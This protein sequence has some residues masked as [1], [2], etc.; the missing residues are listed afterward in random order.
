[1]TARPRRLWTGITTTVQPGTRAS[2]SQP[3][4]D[5]ECGQKC[6]LMCRLSF[7]NAPVGLQHVGII[8]YYISGWDFSRPG[9]AVEVK[10]E[11]GGEGVGRDLSKST[12]VYL[13][14]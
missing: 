14:S 1:M 13:T 4:E 3:S 9:G 8:L 11:G 7:G 6:M 10:G 12:T 5:D 2:L